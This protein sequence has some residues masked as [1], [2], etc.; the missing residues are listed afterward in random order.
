MF[1]NFGIYSSM[2]LTINFKPLAPCGNKFI[3]NK[4]YLLVVRLKS[5]LRPEFA[6]S[7]VSDVNLES[8]STLLVY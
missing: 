4:Q 1:H 6:S 2:K 7:L 3:N 5:L 8:S